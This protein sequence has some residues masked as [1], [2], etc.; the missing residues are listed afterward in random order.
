MKE[1][2]IQ[3]ILED[4]GAITANS[5]F[6]FTHG[7]HSAVYISKDALYPHTKITSQ[8]CK[9]IAE[10]FAKDRVDAVI[11]PVI[12]GVILSQWVAHHLTEIT[13][14]EVFGVYAEKDGAGG[15]VIKRGYD[16]LIAGKNVLVVEDM[17]TTG[18]SAKKVVEAARALGCKVVGLGALFNRNE[19]TAKDVANVPRL[20]ALYNKKLE[21]WPEADCPLCKK[22]VPINTDLGKG[23]EYLARKR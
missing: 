19:T 20:F 16:K 23:R 7:N 9:A 8:L 17:L 10:Q 11:A 1:Q 21:D 2:E 12:G 22:G 14:R 6:V 13:G 18:A 15:F 4:V 3:K 5:H